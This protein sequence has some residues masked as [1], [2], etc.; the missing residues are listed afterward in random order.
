K[1]HM[2]AWKCK[3][4]D[5]YGGATIV[6]GPLGPG[7]KLYFDPPIDDENWEGPFA[8]R[9]WALKRHWICG[10]HAY[11]RLPPNWSGICYVGY[12]R[13]LF[14]LLPQVQENQL[15]I[16]VYD[17]L[18]R[19]KWSIDAALAGGS[20]KKWGK[21]EW[22][23]E[24]IIQ[25]YGPATWNPNELISG[26]R[27]PIYDLNW[28]IRLQAVFEIITYQTATA[29]DL[30]ADQSTQM[31]NVIFQHRMVLDYLLAEER[32]V[33]GRLNDSNCCLQIDDDGQVVKQI[34]K[35]IRKLVHVPVQTWKGWEWDMFSRLPGG[36]WI[37]QML[38]SLLCAI[39]TL[40]FL[41]CMIPCVV[42][43]IQ[44]VIKGMQ[45]VV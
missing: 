19:E 12:I 22:P 5:S 34:A 26:A 43:L 35:G 11:C 10:Q 23:P 31:N 41:L 16:K 17:A 45:V 2:R 6:G 7:S 32:G 36:L 38:F 9:T 13:P 8:N 37:K 21:D 4:C 24:R 44:N 3:Y 25:Y 42:Q 30:L 20:T 27:E 28:I 39:A 33:C 14:F 15:G 29:L 18:I 1:P 40:I